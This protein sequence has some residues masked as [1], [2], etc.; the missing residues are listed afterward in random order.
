MAEAHP[1]AVD[2]AYGTPFTCG[3]RA[4]GGSELPKEAG[5]TTKSDRAKTVGQRSDGGGIPFSS[6]GSNN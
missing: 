5:K 2:S 4:G 6:T 1:D 3:L